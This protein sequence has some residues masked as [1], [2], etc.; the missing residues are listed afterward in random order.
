MNLIMELL[1]DYISTVPDSR[2]AKKVRHKIMDIIMVVFF[3]M[4]GN[5]D[6]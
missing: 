3:A 4:L 2:Q 1:L 5:T 6:D